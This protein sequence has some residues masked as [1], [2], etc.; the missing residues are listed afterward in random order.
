MS[1]IRGKNTKPEVAL[2]K[3][4]FGLGFRYRLHS[5]KVPGRPDIVFPRHRAVV[6]VNGCFWHGHDCRLF[7]WP[8]GNE[9]FWRKKIEGNRRRDERVIRELAEA[10]WRTITVWECSIRRAHPVRVA[11]VAR[12]IGRWLAN[13]RGNG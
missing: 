1:R 3:A 8:Q 11:A 6:L 12:N 2:R 9:A 10:G 13:Q 4:L 7:K 5:K